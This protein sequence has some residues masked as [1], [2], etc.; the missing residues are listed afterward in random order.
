MRE[1]NVESEAYKKLK[2]NIFRD[3]FDFDK[4]P[5]EINL[6]TKSKER[7]EKIVKRIQKGN[8]EKSEKLIVVSGN[9]RVSIFRSLISEYQNQKKLVENLSSRKSNLYFNLSREEME[10]HG[11]Q[12]NVNT[13]TF[14][15][16]STIDILKWCRLKYFQ[17]KERLQENGKEV[18][19]DHIWKEPV[20]EGLSLFKYIYTLKLA[21]H[22]N[23]SEK[24]ASTFKQFSCFE[25]SLFKLLI[26][27]FEKR[28]EKG[29]LDIK[30]GIF[31]LQ[32]LMNDYTDEEGALQKL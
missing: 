17:V 23:I 12:S 25:E 13:T 14:I 20:K 15:K 30:G 9:N 1:I 27:Y 16:E 18:S 19:K 32:F 6:I 29:V 11:S 21:P 22:L 3:Y 2:S 31:S 26:S 10:L 4:T 7:K 28:E 8:L 5:L 24:E